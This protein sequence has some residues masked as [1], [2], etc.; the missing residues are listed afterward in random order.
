[1]DIVTALLNCEV[2]DDD[3]YMMLPDGWPES[4]NAPG[5]VTWLKKV[6]FSLKY[7]PQLWHTDINTFLLSIEFTQSLANPNLYIH[8]DGLPMPFD[9]AYMSLSNAEEGNKAVIDVKCRV[10]EKHNI[11]YL[12]LSCQFLGIEIY[13]KEHCNTSGTTIS[14]GQKA[15]ITTIL[16]WINIQKTHNITAQMKS[17]SKL[18]LAKN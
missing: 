1:M 7:A 3:I 15:F 8:S 10:S 14:L 9:I 5:I 4:L 17:K 13:H 18:D 2:H 6:I 16:K 12:G 11:T